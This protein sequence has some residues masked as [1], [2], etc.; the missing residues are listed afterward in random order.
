MGRLEPEKNLFNLIEALSPTNLTLDIYGSGELQEPLQRKAKKLNVPINFMGVVPNQE[1][2]DFLNRYR[3]YILPSLHEGMPKSL[4][5]AMACGLICI[6]TDVNGINEVI[7]DNVNGLLAQTTSPKALTE[8][9]NRAKQ[10]PA[11]SIS[12]RAVQT[13]RDSFSIETIVQKEKEL[14]ASLKS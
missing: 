11:D 4:L 12:T 10:L 7:E 3:Y 13:I 14:F 1:L 8:A 6:G 2:P 9:I 5:E